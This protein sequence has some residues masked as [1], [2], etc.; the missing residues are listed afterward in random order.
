MRMGILNGKMAGTIK[1]RALVRGKLRFWSDE[2]GTL[3]IFGM[4]LAV[5]MIMMGGIAV[6]VMRYESRRTSLQNALDR[7]TLAA[8]AL[9]PR[10]QRI[11]AAGGV[12]YAGMIGMAPILL[13]GLSEP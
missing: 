8:A 10:I 2:T 1:A 7:S 4:M 12:P 11:W 3:V 6:D 9:T 5:L 13:R